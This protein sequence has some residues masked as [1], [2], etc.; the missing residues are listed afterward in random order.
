MDKKLRETTNLCVEIINT[1][2]QVNE[3]KLGHVV[4]I[5]VLRHHTKQEN[6]LLSLITKCLI[7]MIIR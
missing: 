7:S 3:K 2:R 1:K 5:R 6:K 4:Q